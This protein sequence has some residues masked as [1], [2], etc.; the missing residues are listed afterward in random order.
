MELVIS[1]PDVTF[2]ALRAG[3]ST[4]FLNNC[5]RNESL[6]TTACLRTV[7]GCKLG[8]VTCE[9]LYLHRASFCIRLLLA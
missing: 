8:H 5:D 9:I 2:L 1:F 6:G 7:V 3:F 4:A